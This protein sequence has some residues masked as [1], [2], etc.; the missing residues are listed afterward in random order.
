VF[1][2]K[3]VGTSVNL[4]NAVWSALDAVVYPALMIIATPFFLNRLGAELYGLWML[5][6]TIIASIGVLNVGLGD[7][8][9]KFVTKYLAANDHQRVHRII[10]A[11]YS[12]YL[13]LSLLIIVVSVITGSLVLKTNIFSV[14]EPHRHLFFK[15]MILAGATLSFR[16]IEQ[17][18]LSVFKGYERYDIAS[19]ISMIGKLLVISA[20]VFCVYLGASL[21]TVFASTLAVTSV[22]LLIEA[23]L[24]Y[25]FF[26][27]VNF[28]P[29]FN[30]QD[31]K[32]IASFGLWTWFLSVLGIISGQIDKFI[33]I[34]LS[35]LKTFAYYSVALTI[36]T[37]I[38]NFYSA[39]AAW[40]FPKVSK[41]IF[42]GEK[43]DTLYLQNQFYM[44]GLATLSLIVFYLIKNPVILL[45]LGQATY[46]KT[47]H[48]IDL[49]ICLNFIMACTILPYYFLNGSGFFKLNSLFNVFTVIARL[50]FIPLCYK[51]LDAEGLVIGLIV[52]SCVVIP[53]QIKV[54]YEKVLNISD[55]WIL[56]KTLIPFLLFLLLYKW[57][58]PVFYVLILIVLL[59]Y[60]RLTLWKPSVSGI[61]KQ[62]H[63][64]TV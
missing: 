55:R 26:G 61:F 39:S 64:D 34:S 25:K 50:I 13:A 36:F 63:E 53:F 14:A 47:I 32:E 3:A 20:N 38:H 24:I 7:T 58:L 11:T 6:N 2:L 15:A 42:L 5:V 40:I 46:A 9:I 54:F 59:L 29:K 12:L 48:F 45:W 8:T 52:A 31:V 16:F 28:M 33:V 62:H 49:F 18:F 27:F 1:S 23:Y 56:I 44:M 22:F 37:Q 17:I 43:V 10:S 21:P 30:Q 41:K 57:S 60:F 35:D 51:W 4:K 19:K